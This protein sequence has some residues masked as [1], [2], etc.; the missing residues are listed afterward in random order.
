MIKPRILKGFQDS[1]PKNEIIRKNFIRIIEDNL[2]LNGYE[3]ID[4]PALEY[5]EVLTGKAGGENEKQMYAFEDNGGRKIGLRFDLTVPLARF[6][7]MNSNELVIPFKRYHIAKAWR[8]EKPQKGRFREFYQADFD[9]IG[10]DNYTCEIEVVQNVISLLNSFNI[11][12]FKVNINDRGLIS[13]VLEKLDLKDKEQTILRIFDKYYKIGI[14]GVKSLL[15]EENIP[16]IDKLLKIFRKYDK[17]KD[18]FLLLKEEFNIE[19]TDLEKIYDFFDCS[20]K[21]SNIV[22]D[23]TITRGLDY[24][25][26][27]VF[28]TFLDNYVNFGSICSGGRYKNLTSMFTKQEFSGI[29]GS[30][31]LDRLISYLIENNNDIIKQEKKKVLVINFNQDDI[32]KYYDISNYLQQNNIISEVYLEDSKLK[33]QFKYADKKNIDYCIIL[34]NDEKKN[35]TITL[36]DLRKREQ[37]TFN[38]LDELIKKI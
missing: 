4:T 25:T 21:K 19:N 13:M 17:A 24:Y 3:P 18:Y 1:L 9:I 31:G 15:N 29:G 33:K 12:N 30:I 14:D 34:G 32:V 38:S 37:N 8:G 5:Y 36:K 35:K 28:E 16:S 10:N 22:I 26:G 27:F 20:G 2:T 11:N 7:A 6:V 23:T